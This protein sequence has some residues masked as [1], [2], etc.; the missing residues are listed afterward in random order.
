M[1]LGYYVSGCESDMLKKAGASKSVCITYNLIQYVALFLLV[2]FYL[3]IGS[4]SGLIAQIQNM[5]LM[6]IFCIPLGRFISQQTGNRMAGAFVTGFLFQTL[7][8]TTSA[9]F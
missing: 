8:I 5:I 9:L 1:S 2:L 3:V 4:Y 6:Y 7:M